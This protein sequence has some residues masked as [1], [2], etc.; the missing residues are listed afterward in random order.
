MSLA[1]T[2]G[3]SV[4]VKRADGE[5]V[6]VWNFVT[7]YQNQQV[8]PTGITENYEVF[9]GDGSVRAHPD[10]ITKGVAE[11]LQSLGVEPD[12]EVIDVEAE[13]VELL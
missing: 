9:V 10:Y 12:V 6:K 3:D 8:H 1:E 4:T 13:E 7:V 11:H 2:L 5:Q